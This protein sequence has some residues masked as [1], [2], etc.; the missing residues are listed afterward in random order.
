[1]NCQASKHGAKVIGNMQNCNELTSTVCDKKD[2]LFCRMIM[3]H[4]KGMLAIFY[5]ACIP[6]GLQMNSV[7]I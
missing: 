7:S 2:D 6:A 5:C 4:S 1:M 3:N